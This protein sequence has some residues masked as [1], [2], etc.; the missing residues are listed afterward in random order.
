MTREEKLNWLQT[1][2]NERL[3]KQYE[4]NCQYSAIEYSEKFGVTLEEALFD[5]KETKKEVLKRMK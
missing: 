4:T 5:I 1:V 2:S 3:L